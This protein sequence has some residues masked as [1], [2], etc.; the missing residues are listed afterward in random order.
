MTVTQLVQRLL[1]LPQDIEVVLEG[2]DEIVGVE[3]ELVSTDKD[4]KVAYVAFIESRE[5]Q[6]DRST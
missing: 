3:V 4:T 1:Q 2:G 6:S 5:S